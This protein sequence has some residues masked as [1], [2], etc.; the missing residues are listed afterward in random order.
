MGIRGHFGDPA[1]G[2]QDARQAPRYQLALGLRVFPRNGEVVHG[3]TIDISASG[4]SAM[5]KVEVPV[6]EA[7][8]L[9]FTVPLGDVEV[10][11]V[12]RHRNAF[13]YGFQFIGSGPGMDLITR[14][15]RELAI[16]QAVGSQT[17]S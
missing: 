3:Y 17:R 7:V 8:R 5:L 1:L 9:E 6:G 10:Q 13:R 11:A 12:A 14:T 16:Q 4:I 2:F 15:C